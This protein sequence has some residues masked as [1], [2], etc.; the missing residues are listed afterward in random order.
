MSIIRFL[1][2]IPGLHRPVYN[3]LYSFL[4]KKSKK[5][6]ETALNDI[7]S[8]KN[9]HL[10]ESCFIIGTGPSLK[11][12]DLMTIKKTGLITFAPNRIF[13]ICDKLDWEPTYY[14]C[15]D[16]NII[17]TFEDRIR[18]V[19][20][21]L[22]FLPMEYKN[23]FKESKYRFFILR[24][25]DYYPGKPKFSRNLSYYLEQ[26]YTVTYGA[27][28][29]AVYMGFKNIYLLGVDH[30]YSIYRDSKGRPVRVNGQAKDYP[31]EMT[32]YMNKDTWP[33]IEEST[34]AYEKAA[35]IARKL[36]VHIYNATRG[37]K[38]EAFER[39]DFDKVMCDYAKRKN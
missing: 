30:N 39:V 17:R 12:E 26:G 36:G 28:Q 2:K 7:A 15:Q 4:A 16:H 38:L 21:V 8:L 13:E 11:T 31:K 27:I 23:I 19:P 5:E 33:R 22:S 9:S 10:G 24:E 20:S 14:I 3:I 18:T 34:M 1:R 25:R 29:M 6:N 37:G 32:Q 35:E